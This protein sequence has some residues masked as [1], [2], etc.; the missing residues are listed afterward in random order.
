VAERRRPLIGVTGPGRG[1]WGPRACVHLALTLCGARPRHLRPGDGFDPSRLDGVVITGGH[2]VEPA[3][4][5]SPVEVN[6]RDD[7]ARDEFESKVIGAVLERGRPLLGICRGAQ[8][9]NVALGGTL[10]QDLSRRRRRGTRLTIL[11]LMEIEVESE[12]RLSRCLPRKLRVNCLHRQGI[13]ELGEGLRR[14]A[15]DVDGIPQGI[16]RVDGSFVIGTQWH[17]EFL[18]YD[19]RQWRLFRELV[20]TA[21]GMRE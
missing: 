3:L 16:E 15:F 1:A 7:P 9:L 19:R 11:P 13:E 20:R 21:Q 5:R 2:D 14:N 10:I 4:Y 6:G 12:S 8:L 17:P 18:L